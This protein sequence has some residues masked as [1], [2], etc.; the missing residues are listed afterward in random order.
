M[1]IVREL[2]SVGILITG[3]FEKFFRGESS[4]AQDAPISFDSDED[5][6]PSACR[7]REVQADGR[8]LSHESAVG[9]VTGSALYVDDV[10]ARRDMLVLWPVTKSA[11]TCACPV[12][13][14]VGRRTGAGRGV[15]DD[16]ER[17]PRQE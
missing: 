4:A 8:A 6:V 11:R 5:G 13:R 12:D 17:R 16:R 15:C 1:T 2:H 9:H 10:A 7:V 14:H 3:L